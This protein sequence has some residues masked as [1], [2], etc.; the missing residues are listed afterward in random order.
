MALNLSGY[1]VDFKAVQEAVTRLSPFIHR[2]PIVT[3]GTADERVGRRLFFKAEN[4]QQTG[5]FKIRGALNAVLQL[6]ESNPAV[7]GVAT[8]SAGNHGQALAAA[9]RNCQ[10]SCTV[11]IPNTAP[12]VKVNAIK[13]YGANVVFCEPTPQDRKA[14]SERVCKEAGLTFVSPYDDVHVISGQGTLGLELLE[15]VSDMDAIVVP[16]SGGGLAAGV[17]LAV[18]SVKPQIKIFAAE[19]A[20]KDLEVSLRAG[21]RLWP[22]PP[23]HLETI[24]DGLR[25]QQLG[26]ITWPIAR[27]CLEKTVLTM[28]DDETVAAMK[29]VFERMK[30]VVEP[31]G[32]VPVAAVM[33]DRFRLLGS[34]IKKVSVIMS[35]GNVNLDKLPWC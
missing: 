32:A 31:S 15:Q 26:Q 30:L 17:C 13:G 5:A 1:A 24:A 25:T 16:V 27:D 28:S 23:R 11:V 20:G 8:H 18:K 3:S 14:T 12:Q 10:L 7:K 33:S 22:E 4:L 29:F 19:P 2:T 6:K 9:A 34:D 35:G 21:E